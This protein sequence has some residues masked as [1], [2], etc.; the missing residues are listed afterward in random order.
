VGFVEE[1]QYGMSADEP[2]AIAVRAGLVGR[3]LLIVP[4]KGSKRSSQGKRACAYAGRRAR[5]PPRA[6][7]S[8]VASRPADTRRI[9]REV[10]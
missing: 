6:C 3:L 2:E 7:A 1:L 9:E 5:Q 10:R 4:A 8:R